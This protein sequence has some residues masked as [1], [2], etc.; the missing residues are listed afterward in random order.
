[1]FKLTGKKRHYPANLRIRLIKTGL[2]IPL[3]I[4]VVTVECGRF[5]K[6]KQGD[7]RRLK[8][9][10]T[11]SAGENNPRNSEGDFITLKNGKILF[12]Y[13]HFTGKSGADDGNAILACRAS[14]NNGNS[15][16]AEDVKIVGQEGKM[17]VMSVSLLRMNNGEIALFYLRKNSDCDCIPVIRTSSDEAVSWSDPRD[18]ITDRK[19]YFVLNNS[20]VIQL[21]NGRIMFAVSLHKSPGDS[22]FSEYGRNWSYLS[23]DNGKSWKSGLEVPD[24]DSVILQEPGLIELKN[25]QILMYLRTMSGV[26][27]F[28]YTDDYGNTWSPAKPGN[29]SSPCSPASIVRIPSTGDL[30]L[31]WNDNGKNQK[32]TPLNLAFS[33]DEGKTWNNNT[34]LRNDPAGM[35][36]YPA[37]HF[38]NND[39]LIAY[40]DWS[41]M[42]ITVLKTDIDL[43]YKENR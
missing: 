32:R 14:G 43:I 3:L 42:G 18:C 9:V 13:S 22:V 40:F 30:L 26:Q 28:S 11:L 41:S 31:V 1:M 24:P 27:Y 12:I 29:I 25:G 10:M 33:R 8:E 16:S 5:N 7:Q 2:A 36:C 19:G 17:N 34:V 37:I 35:Y 38:V 23:D 20:R 21:R 15:W 4:L 6:N 39:V